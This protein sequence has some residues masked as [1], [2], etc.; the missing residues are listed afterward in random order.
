MDDLEQR[1]ETEG[2]AETEPGAE[3]GAEAGTEAE[4]G[5]EAQ[6]QPEPMHPLM[7]LAQLRQILEQRVPD[8]KTKINI[9]ALYDKALIPGLHAKLSSLCPELPHPTTSESIKPT[10]RVNEFSTGR[11]P[12]TPVDS[13]FV[14]FAVEWRADDGTFAFMNDALFRHLAQSVARLYGLHDGEYELSFHCGARYASTKRTEGD[15]SKALLGHSGVDRRVFIN[16]P[17][18]ALHDGVPEGERA[19]YAY[20]ALLEETA[21]LENRLQAVKTG[22]GGLSESYS[23]LMAELK[24]LLIE[25]CPKIE[26]DG[27]LFRPS[28]IEIS[29][30]RESADSMNP[31]GMVEFA[32]QY[33]SCSGEI[34]HILNALTTG[35][36]EKLAQGIALLYGGN[37][38]A[39]R[40]QTKPSGS[41]FRRR[42]VTIEGDEQESSPRV[43]VSVL[44]R[45]PSPKHPVSDDFHAIACFVPLDAVKRGGSIPIEA[46]R[47]ECAKAA[48]GAMS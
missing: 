35:E 10:V 45:A 2:A 41:S 26:F 27:R 20:K 18:T 1:Q 39:G 36:L 24:G 5:A 25:V 4:T 29:P 38:K 6:R 42:I 43:L 17:I 15:T 37:V 22:P 12:Y 44:A 33:T 32:L 9:C 46:R 48:R 7:A 23:K 16:M 31:Q 14:N 8:S 13:S 30:L 11:E 21:A 19:L 40:E 3:T 47:G 28:I 34:T